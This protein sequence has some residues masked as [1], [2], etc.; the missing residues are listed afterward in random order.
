MTCATTSG[1]PMFG[2]CGPTGVT[3]VTGRIVSAS[4]TW[5]GSGF[6]FGWLD[7]LNAKLQEV[8]QQCVN[9]PFPSDTQDDRIIW[10]EYIG[11]YVEPRNPPYPV[12]WSMNQ[13]YGLCSGGGFGTG[14]LDDWYDWDAGWFHL[15]GTGWLYAQK[16][17]VICP[18]SRRICFARKLNPSVTT[19]RPCRISGGS[20]EDP[21]Q[22][23]DASQYDFLPGQPPQITNQYGPAIEILTAHV[24]DQSTYP[25]PCLGAP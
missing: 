14:G 18:S 6:P 10:H 22:R 23:I 9:A 21:I 5:G 15:L 7:V 24:G 2:C 3:H 25:S 16:V 4:L 13:N 1:L 11:S 19:A 8:Y 17:R 12:T 20:P